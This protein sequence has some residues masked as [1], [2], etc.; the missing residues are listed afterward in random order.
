[1]LGRGSVQ[2]SGYVDGIIASYLGDV[3]VAAMRNAQT[4]ALLPVSLFGM[5]VAAAELPEMASATGDD[6]ARAAHVQAR[7]RAALRRVVFLVVPSAVAFV[8]IG[9]AMV[10]LLFQ[11]GRFDS[12]D[13]RI[14]WIIL[15][16]SALG[17]SAGTQGRVLNSAF[18]A[19]HD[20]R[21]P[22]Y[23]ALA[24]VALTGV[25]GYLFAL[26]IRDAFGY[27]AE[28][29]AFGLTASAGVAAW[30]EFLLLRRMLAG[31]IGAVPIPTRLGLGALAAAAVAG[32]AGYACW[33]GLGELVATP[34]AAALA[35][36]VFGGVYLVITAIA[37]VDEAQRMLRRVARRLG[38]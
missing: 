11:G 13:T 36:V 33:W 8:T 26:P 18:Y 14:V 22:L 20:T 3:I 30:L 19:L 5:A 1:V 15:A 24:R 9:G 6:A 23:A 4:L 38:R 29:G 7:L 37:G 10:S 25:L 34:I 31:R 2:L 35:C 12:G 16:G 28:W 32:A 17:L 27:S 21:S